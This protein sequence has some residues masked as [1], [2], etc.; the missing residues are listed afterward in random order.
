MRKSNIHMLYGFQ[1]NKLKTRLPEIP[2]ICF[3]V[4]VYK[5]DYRLWYAG[6]NVITTLYVYLYYEFRPLQGWHEWE[7]LKL[8]SHQQKAIFWS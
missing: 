6:I 7:P 4:L 1:V 3:T 8:D 5:E 2:N